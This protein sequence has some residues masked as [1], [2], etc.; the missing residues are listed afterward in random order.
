MALTIEEQ[1]E[2][3]RVKQKEAFARAQSRKIAKLNDPKERE[4]RF[5]KQ[6]AASKRQ[7]EKQRIK[8]NS[9][10]YRAQQ[11]AKAKAQAAKAIEKAKSAPPKKRTPRK[12]TSK[13]LKGRTPT[14]SERRAMDLIGKLPCVA[15]EKHGREN[16]MISLHHVYG[17]TIDN[18]HAYVLPLCCYHHDTLLP[19]EERERYPDMLPVHA[20]GK[21]G[22][23][24]QFNQHNG[25]EFELLVAVYEK[26]GLPIGLLENLS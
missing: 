5:A 1:R 22:G 18:A 26:V 12:T 10:E 2:R 15:C 19:K 23:K 21:Y 11:L 9:P 16:P 4:K 3:Q 7:Q 24:H 20:K 14:A 6:Q 8:L 17:R 25:T 13:G